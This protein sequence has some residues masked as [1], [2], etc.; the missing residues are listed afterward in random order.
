MPPA[1]TSPFSSLATWPDTNTKPPALVARERGSVRVP[2]LLSSKNSIVI[3]GTLCMSTPPNE[4][5]YPR[6]AAGAKRCPRGVRV[7]RRVRRR[8]GHLTLSLWGPWNVGGDPYR[9]YQTAILRPV[10][11]CLAFGESFA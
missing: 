1:T 10:G 6:P 7:D 4:L 8:V 9:W 2:A 3:S 5:K 11:G